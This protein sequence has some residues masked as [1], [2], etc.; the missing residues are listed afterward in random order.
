MAVAQYNIFFVTQHLGYCCEVCLEVLRDA[1]IDTAKYT[2]LK[3]NILHLRTPSG[4][5]AEAARMAIA[6]P[7]PRP[8]E[9]KASHST[10]QVVVLHNTTGKR[11]NKR[12]CKW[13]IAPDD[14]K[15]DVPYGRTVRINSTQV[16]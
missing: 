4:H 1:G 8:V 5:T 12:E 2:F 11:R 13:L 3:S 16:R 10:S 9:K 6:S 7:E 14:P 15:P